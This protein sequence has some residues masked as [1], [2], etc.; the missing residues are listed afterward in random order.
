MLNIYHRFH[1][2]GRFDAFFSIHLCSTDSLEAS[3]ASISA[4]LT[5]TIH[6]VVMPCRSGTLEIFEVTEAD[7]AYAGALQTIQHVEHVVEAL[8]V[9]AKKL[10]N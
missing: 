8:V 7:K 2:E 9:K 1:I 5:P 4:P 3:S 10:H 6:P